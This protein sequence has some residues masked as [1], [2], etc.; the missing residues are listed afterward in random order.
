MRNLIL[1]VTAVS[2][3]LCPAPALAQQATAWRDSAQRLGVAVRALRDS[4]LQGDSTTVEVGRRGDLV[5][6]ASVADRSTALDALAAFAQVRDRWFKGGLPSPDGFRIV[7]RNQQGTGPAPDQQ[8]GMIVLSALP[9]TGQSIRVQRQSWQSNA[10]QSLIDRY[11]EMMIAS[12]AP[13]ALWIE[14]PPPLSMAETER[15]QLSM[16]A[17]VTATGSLSRNCVSG[18][19]A[20]CRFAM[21][22]EHAPSTSTDAAFP[23]FMRAD[24]LYYT[25]DTGG[26]GAWNRLH[27]AAGGGLEA[28]LAAAAQ[29]PI[30]SL[31]AHWRSSLLALRPTTVTIS[32]RTALLA[33]TWSSVLLLGALGASRWA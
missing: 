1:A 28:G 31:V 17:F 8:D 3:L 6:A 25:L 10:A 23:K 26:P 30:D 14:E 4:M 5:I 22:I 9:D 12:V 32:M 2:V 13:L 16:Y 11:G 21:D 20:A 29:M 19:L 18:D 7:L 27:G 24:F 33:L 15:R